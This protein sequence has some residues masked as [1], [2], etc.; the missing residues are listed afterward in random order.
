[1]LIVENR[2]VSPSRMNQTT[3]EMGA[4]AGSTVAKFLLSRQLRIF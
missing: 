2:I 4:A 3:D 1:V